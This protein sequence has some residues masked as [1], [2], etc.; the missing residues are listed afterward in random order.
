VPRIL[1]LATHPAGD[2]IPS[3]RTVPARLAEDWRQAGRDAA[4]TAEARA[5]VRRDFG[6]ADTRAPRYLVDF[7][8]FGV[9]EGERRPTLF[10]CAAWLAEQGAP[11]ALVAALLTEP[12]RDLGLTTADV[13]RQIRCGIDHARRQGGAAADPRPD[14]EADPD[15]FERWAIRHEADPLSTGAPDFRFGALALAEGGAA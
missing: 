3:A 2:G 1:D 5:A 10:R 15:A 4:R 7:L 12:G 11:P 14:P 6:T 13:D 8:R 9:E